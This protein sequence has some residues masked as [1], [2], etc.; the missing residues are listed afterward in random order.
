MNKCFINWKET[1]SPAL[2]A[3]KLCWKSIFSAMDDIRVNRKITAEE[4]FNVSSRVF[5][6]LIPVTNK[7]FWWATVENNCKTK[8]IEA[9]YQHKARSCLLPAVYAGEEDC[10]SFICRTHLSGVVNH[11]LFVTA[12]APSVNLDTTGQNA[13][14]FTAEYIKHQH[15]PVSSHHSSLHFRVFLLPQCCWWLLHRVEDHTG[16]DLLPTELWGR[17]KYIRG[18]LVS[19]F[20]CITRKN[21]F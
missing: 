11:P 2:F 20:T 8:Q 17:N 1:N 18:L 14:Q 19:L 16:V 4:K 3:N 6:F 21:N 5:L 10:L 13:S 7:Y 9:K 15:W 12:R